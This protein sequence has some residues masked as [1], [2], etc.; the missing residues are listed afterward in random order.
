MIYFSLL[1]QKIRW[2][3]LLLS[4]SLGTSLWCMIDHSL[5]TTII[6]DNVPLHILS[7]KQEGMVTTSYPLT[8]TIKGK[9][10]V[11]KASQQERLYATILSSQS[12][13]CLPTITTKHLHSNLSDDMMQN[14]IFR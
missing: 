8:L 12:Y 5:I 14:G 1:S 3:H 2:G 11:L 6:F 7:E 4:L 13:Q 10:G 9:K